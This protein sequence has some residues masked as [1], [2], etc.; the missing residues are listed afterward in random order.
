[1]PVI[2][3]SYKAPWYVRNAHIHTMWPVLF[4]RIPAG[5]MPKSFHRVR[6]DTEDGDFLDVDVYE[7]EGEMR[8]AAVL[9]HGLEGNSRRKY[10]LG[11]TRVLLAEGFAVAAWNMR[12]C[13]GE[14]NRTDRLYHMGQTADLAEVIRFA[15]RWDR[16]LLLAGFSMG[17]AQTAMYLGREKVSPLARAAVLVSVPCDLVGAA[18]VM[19]GP[20]CRLYMEYFLR[21]MCAKVKKKAERFAGYPSVEGIDRFHTFAEF[22]GR[23]T[24]P[25]YGYKNALD[26]WSSNTVLPYLPNIAVPS[27]M[28]LAADDPFLSPSCYPWEVAQKSRS[29][30]LEV[31]PHGGHVGFVQSGPMY[32]SE[33]RAVQF[34]R[35]IWR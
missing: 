3:S 8:G 33:E 34:A 12:G 1:M 26:Y 16:P 14:P 18:R 23:F 35:E 6:L 21:P 11:L 24:A 17:G 9:T 5:W 30:R 27:Y 22:D 20:S 31:V 13:S 32:Y 7:P 25:L 10:I 15:E 2:S 19:D 29:L 4:R 28:L